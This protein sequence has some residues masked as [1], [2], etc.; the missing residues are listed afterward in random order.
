VP[1]DRPIVT[2][3]TDFQTIDFYVA[4]VKAVLL[5]ANRDV[6]IVDVTHAIPRH[7]IVAG[8]ITLERAVASFPAGTLHLAVV[9]P[10]VGTHRR[11]L[12][13][14]VAEQIVVCPDNGL[15]TWAMR[16]HVSRQMYELTWRPSQSSNTFHGRDV[17]APAVAMLMQGKSIAEIAKP[18]SDTVLLDLHL[19]SDRRRG[20]IIHID[21][22]G[23]AMTN[24]PEALLAGHRNVPV[25]VR[26]QNIGQIHNTYGD[27]GIGESL[28]LIGSSGLLEIAIRT[29]NAAAEMNL[30]V[31]DGV[32]LR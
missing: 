3:T 8:S 7:D 17:M 27:V 9:D 29:G 32:A 23:N 10:G 16:R 14:E 4:A 31:G 18:V 22:Y 12:I 15:I 21:T 26:G 30:K 19:A 1:T 25:H 5:T 2:L 28:A 20:Q 13:A 24:L 6:C 11:I